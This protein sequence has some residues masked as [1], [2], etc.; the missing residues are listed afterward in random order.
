MMF[1][2]GMAS[3]FLHAQ[4]SVLPTDPNDACAEAWQKYH[5]ADKLWK[6]GWGLFGGGG[7]LALAGGITCAVYDSAT[8][9]SGNKSGNGQQH[10]SVGMAIGGLSAFFVTVIGGTVMVA[11]VPCICVGHSRRKRAMDVINTQCPDQPALTFSIQ[12][13]SNGVG[14]AM[15]F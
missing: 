6:T 2:C 12:S 8:K 7:A 5:K 15:Q 13:S 4:G 11:S 14:I 3:G 10:Y 1:L 9:D